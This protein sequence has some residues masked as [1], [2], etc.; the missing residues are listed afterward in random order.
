MAVKEKTALAA[1]GEAKSRRPGRM[2]TMVVSQTARK[3][4]WVLLLVFPK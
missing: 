1:M 3:G 4:V 2:E